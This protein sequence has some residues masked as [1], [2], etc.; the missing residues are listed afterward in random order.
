[1]KCSDTNL[2]TGLFF[3]AN[4]QGIDLPFGV[5]IPWG[6]GQLISIYAHDINNFVDVDWIIT[7]MQT[8]GHP[9]EEGNYTY[10]CVQLYLYVYMQWRYTIGISV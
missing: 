4:M 10:S 3:N 2:L 7:I 9:I 8:Q 5:F 6:D 1:M